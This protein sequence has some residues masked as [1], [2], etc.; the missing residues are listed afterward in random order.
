MATETKFI[1]K[2]DE[3]GV[4]I[5][6]SNLLNISTSPF[7]VTIAFGKAFINPAETMSGNTEVI[8]KFEV[9]V[10]MSPEH[11]RSL[12]MLLKEQMDKYTARAGQDFTKESKH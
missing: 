11:A 3:E 4:N 8:Q 2:F 10:Q 5:Y 7:D 9:M 1:R 12:L 6:Y